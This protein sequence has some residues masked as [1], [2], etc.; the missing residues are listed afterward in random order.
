ML[1]SQGAQET[2]LQTYAQKMPVYASGRGM[3]GNP[4]SILDKPSTRRT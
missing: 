4:A 1:L 2:F 3:Y